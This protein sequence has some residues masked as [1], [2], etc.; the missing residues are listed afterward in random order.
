MDSKNTLL[1][2]LKI[3]FNS[4]KETNQ[5]KKISPHKEEHNLI[6]E[7]SPEDV[8]VIRGKNIE[9]SSIKKFKKVSNSNEKDKNYLYN[10]FN[11]TNQ[12]FTM[13]RKA[14]N[15]VDHNFSIE[16]A[17]LDIKTPEHEIIST[18]KYMY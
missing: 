5:K 3:K 2:I 13:K 8:K 17:R 11:I 1:C 6:E 4:P 15:K 18:S 7:T 14:V 9:G 16:G 12:I 10:Q